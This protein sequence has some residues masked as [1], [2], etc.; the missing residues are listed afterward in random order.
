MEKMMDAFLAA[1]FLQ[2]GYNTTIVT[3]G[4]GLLGASA[5]AIGTFV[6]LRKRSLV[7]DAISHATLPGLALAFIVMA[8]ATGDGRS[9]IGLMIGSALS[10]GLGLL[11][12]DWLTSRTRLSEDAAIGAVLS[13][14][15]GAGVVLMTVIQTLN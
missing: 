4:A 14:F 6:L 12:V 1:L 13:V 7:S 5:G 2:A 3:I 8:A 9:I 10:A 11:V 15:F